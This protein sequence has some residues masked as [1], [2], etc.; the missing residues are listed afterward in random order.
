[1]AE[2]TGRFDEAPVAQYSARLSPYHVC[3][4]TE[5]LRRY[6]QRRAGS[7][8]SQHR[9][10]GPDSVHHADGKSWNTENTVVTILNQTAS[11]A[12][13]NEKTLAFGFPG[14]LKRQ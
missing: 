9:V 10:P 7:G 3:N 12:A 8:K 1:M 5:S 6:V 4:E 14:H 13:R 2:E 11:G